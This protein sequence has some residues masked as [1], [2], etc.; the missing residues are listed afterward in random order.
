MRQLSNYFFKNHVT[1]PYFS[2][3]DQFAGHQLKYF[4]G[5]DL[6]LMGDRGGQ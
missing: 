5:A 1:P 4:G 2:I 6:H 3:S